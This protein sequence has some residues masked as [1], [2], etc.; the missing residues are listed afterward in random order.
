MECGF[1]IDASIFCGFVVQLVVQQI[2]NKLYKWRLGLRDTA[3]HWVLPCH[4]HVDFNGSGL[5]VLGPVL[6][7]GPVSGLTVVN[8]PNIYVYSAK[9]V[10][11]HQ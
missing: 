4:V 10:V 2:Q 5:K 8:N 1:A 6:A 9:E 11:M 7:Q 3:S